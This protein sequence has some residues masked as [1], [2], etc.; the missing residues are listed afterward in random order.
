MVLVSQARPT[1]A[2]EGSPSLSCGSRSGLQDYYGFGLCERCRTR[3]M[4]L[5][6]IEYEQLYEYAAFHWY[7]TGSSK[8]QRR[9]IRRRCLEHFQAEDGVLY[10]SSVGT[11]KVSQMASDSPDRKWKIVVRSEE[12][13]RRIME[14]CHSSPHGRCCM[15]GIILYYLWDVIQKPFVSLGGHFGRDKTY[16]KITSR[17]YWPEMAKEVR[18]Y[19]ASCDICQRTNDGKFVKA[20][21]S[22]HPIKVEP[23]VWRMV[24]CW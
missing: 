11:S 16:E 17:F 19:V 10:Y 3:D 12:E 18:E 23:E 1:S 22:L 4:G 13:R 7:P 15:V 9:I 8:N 2:R 6:A 20:A 24:R 5:T 21:P 14:S